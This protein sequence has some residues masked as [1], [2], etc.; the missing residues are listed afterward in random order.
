MDSTAKQLLA[1]SVTNDLDKYSHHIVDGKLVAKTEN[2]DGN[3]LKSLADSL[4]DK[5]N[6]RFIFIANV[7]DDKLVF[8]CKSNKSIH[9]GNTVKEAAKIATG[10]RELSCLP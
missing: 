2:I 6:L 7:Q 1:Q 9:C 4:Y 8:V 5:F 3:A 10:G